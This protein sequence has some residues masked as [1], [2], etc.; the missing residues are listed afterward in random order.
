M[1]VHFKSGSA[2]MDFERVTQWLS[3]VHWSKGITRAEVEYGAMHSALVVGG[4]DAS[5]EQ[6]SYLRVVS[7]RVRFAY[8]MDVVVHLPFRGRG[9]GKRMMQFA[10]EHPDMRFV[11]QWVLRT[12]DAQGLYAQLGFKRIEG[13]DQWMIVQRPRPERITFDPM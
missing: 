12:S 5:D 3:E 6:V 13:S 7:D 10:L 1:D 8:V 2:D 9:I 4:F 11:Y